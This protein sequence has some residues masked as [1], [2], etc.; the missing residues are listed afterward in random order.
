M[1]RLFVAGEPKPQGSK[2][3]Y[4]RGNR[5]VLVE[6][7]KALPGWR[8]TV[9][10][11]LNALAVDEPIDEAVSIQLDFYLTRP[12]SNKRP[13]MT[14]KP[15]ID[16]LERAILDCLTRTGI[17]RDDSLVVDLLGTKHYADEHP[18]GVRIEIHRI[19]N[20]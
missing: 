3:A 12:A 16:K 7:N 14:T 18:A 13:A 1:I 4:V 17:L 6:A 10:S 20:E 11:A 8:R 19:N 15:D 5:A 9:E 2:T